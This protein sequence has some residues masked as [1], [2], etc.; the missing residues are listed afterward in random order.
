MGAATAEVSKE[1]PGV[2]EAGLAALK[3][4]EVI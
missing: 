3:E 1:L 4:E 2:D